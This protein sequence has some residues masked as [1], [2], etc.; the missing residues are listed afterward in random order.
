MSHSEGPL[1]LWKGGIWVH[2]IRAIK[3]GRAWWKQMTMCV[4]TR[5][6]EREEGLPISALQRFPPCALASLSYFVI[7][8][9]LGR[10]GALGHPR[11]FIPDRQSGWRCPSALG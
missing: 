8:E 7:C 6:S 2:H 10:G 11:S 1:F 4:S 5:S 9:S 3:K